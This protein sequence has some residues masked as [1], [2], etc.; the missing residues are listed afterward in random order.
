MSICLSCSSLGPLVSKVKEYQVEAIVDNLCNNMV[1]KTIVWTR[2][3][4]PTYMD[5]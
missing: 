2:I 4:L 1:R 3:D 5:W